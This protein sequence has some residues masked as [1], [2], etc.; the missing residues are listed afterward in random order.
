M[1]GIVLEGGGAR[2]AYQVGVWKALKEL[3]ISYAGVAGTSVGAINGAMMVQGD[4][5]KA[6]DVWSNLTPSQVVRL[7]EEV[8]R[9]DAVSLLHAVKTLFR[10][11]G[12]DVTPLRLLLEQCLDERRVRQGGMVLGLIT[13]SLPDFY[14]LRLY[15][16][17]IPSGKLIDY[18]LAS[19]NL[20]L[21]RRQKVD[22]RTFLDGGIYD[23]L[24][25][26]LLTGRGFKKI[27]A[28]RLTKK[29]L[30]RWKMEEGVEITVIRPGESLGGI[31]DFSGE[32]AEKNIR[33]GYYDAIR[34]LKGYM[35]SRYCIDVDR[36]E[37][38]FFEMVM[39]V[40]EDSLRKLVQRLGLPESVPA[41][42]LL[43][44]K[45]VPLAIELLGLSYTASYRD[46]VVALLER[47]AERAGIE[48]FKV[49]RYHQLY[50]EVLKRRR[51]CG[52][53][54]RTNLPKI[55]QGNELILKAMG[56][57]VLDEL[58]NLLFMPQR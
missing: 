52:E 38:Y 12:M 56:D 16:E 36:D 3:G 29:D 34:I 5:E 27:I 45:L 21:F 24:P 42:R 33:L 49:Y 14:P 37:R 30:P 8:K 50:D 2:G 20:P 57:Q 44:E 35:G 55:F 32:K 23:N 19:A 10:E 4:I 53:H 13:I 40:E 39:G 18:L 51:V 46:M 11:G 41:R 28:V 48:R 25:I 31:L 17:D 15:L 1:Y 26:G 9:G 43:L 6:I 22:G 54:T 58:T 47:A 7:N